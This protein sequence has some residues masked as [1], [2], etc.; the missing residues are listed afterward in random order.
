MNNCLKYVVYNLLVIW[1]PGMWWMWWL[2]MREWS[3]FFIVSSYGV[4]LLNYVM[5][6]YIGV[7]LG[8]RND[9]Q[10][11]RTVLQR[12]YAEIT[13]G[14]RKLSCFYL[15]KL[16]SE[17]KEDQMTCSLH[18]YMLMYWNVVCAGR[19]GMVDVLQLQIAFVRSFLLL[20]GCYSL[21]RWTDFYALDGYKLG[22]GVVGMFLLLLGLWAIR[23]WQRKIYRFVI[24]SY[25]YLNQVR[26]K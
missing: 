24:E 7:K 21:T 23:V 17:Y 14:E 18:T 1:G 2:G 25:E 19:Q 15:D 10:G 20:I 16:L 11:I 9:V 26:N 13:D 6:D 5:C 12:Y 3:V 22:C 8:F 4:G